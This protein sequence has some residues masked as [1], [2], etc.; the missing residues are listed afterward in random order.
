ML[1]I[2][3][4]RQQ[5][6]GIP[7]AGV[8]EPRLVRMALDPE[9]GERF[10]EAEAIDLLNKGDNIPLC[11]A[12]ET[13]KASPL[14]IHRERWLFLWVERTKAARSPARALKVDALGN[15]FEN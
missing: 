10:F 12:A 15:D 13:V 5:C 6:R 1:L 9:A 7:C 2:H 4:G 11:V 3:P 8:D 14:F